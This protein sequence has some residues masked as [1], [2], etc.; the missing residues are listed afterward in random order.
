MSKPED[1]AL[2]ELPAIDT[3]S[4]DD[5]SAG[6]TRRLTAAEWTEAVTLFETGKLTKSDLAR[7]FGIS[8]QSMFAGLKQR[9]AVYG[10]KTNVIEEA[11]LESEK[12][13][14]KKKSEEVAAMRERQRVSTEL[15]QKL[16]NNIIGEAL[17]DRANLSTKYD[18]I[19]TINAL[20]KN[21]KM[22][23]EELW[24]I[25]DLNR[26]PDQA[27]EMPDF[28]VSEYEPAELAAINAKTFG[29]AADETL[30]EIE[31]TLEPDADGTLPSIEDLMAELP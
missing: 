18:E 1:P 7:K 14:Q 27:D 31:R 22:F 30:D 23:R 20:I 13:D 3:P 5:K 15:L 19:R 8:F 21:Q 10:S 26:D 9:G 11:I 4:G 16:Q 25:Y 12:S 2:S 28:V 24:G 29:E 6:P 17:R